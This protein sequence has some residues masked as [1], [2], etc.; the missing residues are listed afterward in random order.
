MENFAQKKGGGCCYKARPL[1]FTTPRAGGEGGIFAIELSRC[2]HM[3]MPDG[4]LSDLSVSRT[5]AR[6]GAVCR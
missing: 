6:D 4:S 2:S 5:T 1:A 3:P